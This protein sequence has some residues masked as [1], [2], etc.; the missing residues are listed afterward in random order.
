MVTP[1]RIREAGE[2]V[3]WLRQSI[4]EQQL[5]LPPHAMPLLKTTIIQ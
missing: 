3:E 1:E 2:F 4:H 5:E